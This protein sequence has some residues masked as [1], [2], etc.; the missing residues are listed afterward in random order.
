MLRNYR[1]I[2]HATL[3]H[4]QR[5]IKLKSNYHY[6]HAGD[7]GENVFFVVNET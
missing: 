1:N 6:L 3:G 7:R 4:A 5:K 2:H